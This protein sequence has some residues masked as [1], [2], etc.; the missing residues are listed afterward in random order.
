MLVPDSGKHQYILYPPDVSEE[1]TIYQLRHLFSDIEAIA[2]IPDAMLDI[3]VNFHYCIFLNHTAVACLGGLARLVESRG[4]QV[5]FDWETLPGAIQANL[6]QNGFLFEF[7]CDQF[8]WDGNSV[9]YWSGC[10]H[11]ATLIGEYLQYKWLGKGWMSVSKALREAITGQ[12]SEIYLNAYEHSQSEVGVFS[13][14]QH[15]PTLETLHL[16]VVDFGIGIPSSVRSLPKNAPLNSLE[17]LSW[18]FQS[19]T[20]TIQGAVSRGL[21]LNLLQEFITR[22][23]G[24]LTVFSNDSCVTVDDNGVRYEDRSIIFCG[25]L[26]NIALRCDERYYCLASEMALS[27]EPLF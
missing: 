4:G 3:R 7:G 22:N 18:A 21:G 11:D 5:I 26:F 2:Q 12:V 9:P 14:G 23:H 27:E 8:P 24:S 16:T 1:P 19:G 17:S 6:A 25:T 15:Y 10:K 13:C 20:T